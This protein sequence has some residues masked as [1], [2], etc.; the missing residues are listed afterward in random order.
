VVNIFLEIKCSVSVSILSKI[1]DDYCAVY[2][3]VFLSLSSEQQLS[4]MHFALK[5]NVLGTV[6]RKCT[7]P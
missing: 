5:T 2:V 7:I 3:S 6:Q 1:S 4:W